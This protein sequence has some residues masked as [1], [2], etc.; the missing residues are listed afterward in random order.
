MLLNTARK[1]V[2]PSI[3]TT[4]SSLSSTPTPTSTPSS[5]SHL[6]HFHPSFPSCLE[7]RFTSSFLVMEEVVTEEEEQSFMEEME[8]HLKRHVYEKDHWDDAIEVSPSYV[9]FYSSQGFRETERKVF[10]PTNAPIV[11]RIK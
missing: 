3:S 2:L 6:Y 7:E 8:S 4:A 1:R 10:K 5:T 9:A 11:E